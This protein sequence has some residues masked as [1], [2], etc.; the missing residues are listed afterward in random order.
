LI[1]KVPITISV[2]FTGSVN[3]NGLTFTWPSVPG[4]TYEVQDTTDFT[5]W[6]TLAVI[7]A[8]GP[9]I[10]YTDPRPISSAPRRFNQIIQVP[11]GTL[12][13][14]ISIAPGPNIT[15]T[16]NSIV[17]GNYEVDS[18]P[19]MVTWT[20]LTVPPITATGPITSYTD[21]TPIGPG[22]RFYRVVYL[23]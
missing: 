12:Y 5:T 1:S 9:T 23:P 4:E 10:S 13:V 3:S 11:V 6:T 17:N 18:S 8:T 22:P 21:P 19:D 16:W 14:T 15:L 7:T 20:A 2:S